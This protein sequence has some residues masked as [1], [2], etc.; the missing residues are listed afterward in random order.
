MGVGERVLRPGRFDPRLAFYA[1]GAVGL[2]LASAHFV[3]EGPA[4]GTTLEVVILVT[5]AV[6]T[7][8]TGREL[9]DRSLSERGAIDAFVYTCG[10]AASFVLLAFAIVLIWHVDHGGAQESQFI[11]VFAFVLGTAVGSRANVYAVEYRE[12]YERNQALTKLLTVN[13]R[14]L[15]H[16]LR[17]EVTIVLGYLEDVDD[18]AEVK[19]VRRHL[20]DLLETSHEARRIAEIW[21]ED[22]TGRFDCTTLLQDRVSALRERNPDVDVSIECTT[23]LAVTANV[24]LPEAIDELLDNAVV[25]NPADVEITASCRRTDEGVVISVA[26]TGVGIPASES[27]VLFSSA[28]TALEHGNGLGLWLVYWTVQRS[29][30]EIRFYERDGGGSVVE[31]ILPETA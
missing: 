28:E 10:F 21:E 9:P 30:G 27:A 23:D 20:N 16:N 13:Q 14:V 25:H 31:M 17:N 8:Y 2:G 15:R 29:D 12:S 6:L 7:A 5:L 24:G 26:D 19:L 1:L 4:I 18:A 11:V 3:L 22:G